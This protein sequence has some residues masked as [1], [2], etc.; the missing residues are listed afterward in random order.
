MLATLWLAT[1]ALAEHG[2]PA[3]NCPAAFELHHFMDHAEHPDHHIGLAQDLNGDGW[4]C[5][6][7]LSIG[8]HIHVDNTLR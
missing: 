5:M 4:I 7:P 6:R 2:A 8:L 1:P 3:G